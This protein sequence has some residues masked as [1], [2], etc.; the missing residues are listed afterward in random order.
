MWYVFGSTYTT[1]ISH[2]VVHHIT[3]LQIME[4]CKNDFLPVSPGAPSNP[5]KKV[6]SSYYTCLQKNKLA[7]PRV[8]WG[9]SFSYFSLVLS[10]SLPGSRW[11]IQMPVC[12]CLYFPRCICVANTWTPAA[13][14]HLHIP[15]C[16]HA[17]LWPTR[18]SLAWCIY[19]NA[20]SRCGGGFDALIL[21]SG[22]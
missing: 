8:V 11:N 9:L 20:H 1:T 4:A 5:R 7:Y 16:T 14:R 13:Q 2:T 21:L 17:S 19:T 3:R 12:M 6:V 10:V 22:Q 18:I 15:W